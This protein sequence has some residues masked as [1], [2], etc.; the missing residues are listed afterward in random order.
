M[1]QEAL[2]VF[3]SIESYKD[4]A[5]IVNRKLIFCQYNKKEIAC[6]LC[7]WSGP[8][9]RDVHIGWSMAEDRPKSN[10]PL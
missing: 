6:I 3:L 5:K 7:A 8:D 4:V 9:S 10:A 1:W 2:P